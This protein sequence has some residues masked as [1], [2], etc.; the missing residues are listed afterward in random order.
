[1]TETAHLSKQRLEALTDGI[2]AIMLTLLVLEIRWPELHRAAPDAEIRAAFRSVWQPLFAFGV[3]FLLGSG[4]WLLHHRALQHVRSVD[5]RFVWIN[6]IFLLFVSLLPFS[7]AALSHFRIGSGF[8]KTLY[9]GHQFIVGLLLLVMW[10]YLHRTG[11]LHPDPELARLR[12]RMTF[13]YCILP[14][15]SLAGFFTS[16]AAPSWGMNAF[17]FTLL[18]GLIIRRGYEKI[19]GMQSATG[20]IDA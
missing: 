1:M 3:T 13:R 12:R 15:A 6:L 20:R 10:I 8:T 7:T 11:Q 18:L 16:L 14:L 4:Y 2:F 9:F 17:G 19:A 5:Q